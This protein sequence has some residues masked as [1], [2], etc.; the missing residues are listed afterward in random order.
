M[1]TKEM[2]EVLADIFEN[3]ERPDKIR[4]TV[5]TETKNLTVVYENLDEEWFREISMF[6]ADSQ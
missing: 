5:N 2:Q 6:C 3:S 4:I 1:A